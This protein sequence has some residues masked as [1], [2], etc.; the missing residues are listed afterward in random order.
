MFLGNF[1]NHPPSETHTKALLSFLDYAV[2]EKKVKECYQILMD[3]VNRR[4]LIDLASV[5]KAHLKDQRH[6]K[7]L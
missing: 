1:Y 4:Y 7:N 6:C 3:H 2:I 5:I